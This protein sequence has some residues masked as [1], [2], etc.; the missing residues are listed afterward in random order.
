MK[1]LSDSLE[2]LR[3]ALARGD[4]SFR[5]IVPTATMAE[6]V[7]NLIAREGFLLRRGV[8]GTLSKFLEPW[9]EEL[10]QISGPLLYLLVDEVVGRLKRPEFARAAHFPGFGVALARM[11][12]EL[13][14]AGCDPPALSEFVAETEAPVPL[15]AAFAAVY[16]EVEIELIARGVGMRATRLRRAAA[17]IRRSGTGAVKSVWLEGFYRINAP[18]RDLI[19]ALRRHADVTVAP[20][21]DEFERPGVRTELVTAP[22]I[23]READEIARRIRE[24]AEAGR[25]FQEIGVILRNPDIYTPL[26]AATFERF[27]IPA[28]FYFSTPLSDHGSVRYLTAA[29]DAMLGGWDHALV[30]GAMRMGASGFGVT[31]AMDWFDFEVRK[32]LPG[33]GIEALREIVTMGAESR[34]SLLRLLD[35]LS[36]LENLRVDTSHSP[37][38][39]ATRTRSLAARARLARP[40][41]GISW[42]EVAVSRGQ[43]EA[44]RAFEAAMDDAADSFPGDRVRFDEFWRRAKA[45]LRLTPLRVA[46]HRRNVVHVMSAYEARQWELP[47]VFVCGLLERQFPRHSHPDPFFGDRARLAL[48]E[49][50]IAVRTPLEMD[51]DEALLFHI[52]V[53]RATSELTLS[54]PEMDARGERNLPSLFLDRFAVAP[55]AALPVSTRRA[56]PHPFQRGLGAIRDEALLNVLGAQHEVMK[57]TALESFLQCPFQFFGIYTLKLRSAPPRPEDRLDSRVLGTIV[58]RV[59]AE[60]TPARP[61]IEPLFGRIFEE[62]CTKEHVPPG[63]RR[64][65]LGQQLLQ[66]LLRMTADEKLPA[67]VAS[68]T[69]VSFEEQIGG[70]MVRGRID[71]IDRLPSGR[72]LVV[73]YKYSLQMQKYV[74]ND[75]S[76]QGPLYAIAAERLGH[77]VAAMLYCGVRGGTRDSVLYTGWTDGLPELKGTYLPLTQEWLTAAAAKVGT[78]AAE[79]R[80]G[81][82]APKPFSTAPCRYCDYRDVCRYEAEEAVTAGA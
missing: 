68:E 45:V 46:D 54:Y 63:Y 81:R 67:A 82:V 9:V 60:W 48:K 38:E 53:T 2:Q 23:E 35:S 42:S 15:G 40:K 25:E 65:A 16:R 50:G 30:L 31:G 17:A 36:D 73:D 39:W 59:L 77:D 6:H 29:V 5:L 44:L 8:V 27:G 1:L 57:P 33:R 26:L 55:I 4:D 74:K 12:E 11:I 47:V 51:E 19:D 62:V 80:E 56:S 21:S 79:I 22:V 52:A 61:P 37:K 76:L 69:E 58:H 43:A 41:D 70:V 24:H 32:Q 66:D 49:R 7:R 20:P 71:R 28:R 18:E 3:A 75:N 78:A 34:A 14:A 64:E 13:S 72:S 10:P